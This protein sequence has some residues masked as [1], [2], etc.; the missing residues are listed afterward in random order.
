MQSGAEEDAALL[1]DEAID[2]FETCVRESIEKFVCVRKTLKFRS[3]L[4]KSGNSEPESIRLTFP[5]R[6]T[7]RGDQSLNTQYRN[8]ILRNYI[9]RRALFDSAHTMHRN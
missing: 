2:A 4:S 1:M 5:N 7:N 3:S 9:F 8:I 6:E